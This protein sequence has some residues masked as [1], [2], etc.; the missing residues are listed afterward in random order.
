MRSLILT[1]VITFIFLIF[2]ACAVT[3]TAAPTAVA[4]NLPADGDEFRFIYGSA[5]EDVF[6]DYQAVLDLHCPGVRRDLQFTG[7]THYTVE[8]F[9]D[10]KAY[11]AGLTDEGVTGSPACS[12]DG[13]ISLVSPR[14]PIR[15]PG[16]SYD[17][18]LMMAVHEYAHLLVNEINPDVPIWLAEGI[19]CY[20]GAGGTYIEKGGTVAKALPAIAFSAIQDSYYGTPAADVY[21]FL[22][23]K[24]I[25]DTY[26]LDKLNRL[27][28]NTGDIEG[29]LGVN[30]LDFEKQWIGFVQSYA[31]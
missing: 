14:S 11:D 7:P 6:A 17:Q 27:L 13:K 18:R 25:I 12:G 10:Q 30:T 23:V 15:V 21:S 19:A 22:A 31:E 9:P 1:L 16:I 3:Q 4:S 24:Y 28:R 2:C 8:I 5:D 26:G 20:E 29:I